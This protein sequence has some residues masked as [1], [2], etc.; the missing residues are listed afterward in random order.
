MLRCASRVAP[1]P[2]NLETNRDTKHQIFQLDTAIK[3][4]C[5]MLGWA[6]ELTSLLQAK[7]NLGGNMLYEILTQKDISTIIPDQFFFQ[8]IWNG[9]LVQLL[10]MENAQNQFAGYGIEFPRVIASMIEQLKEN[11]PKGGVAS[12]AAVKPQDQEA[13]NKEEEEDEDPA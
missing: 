4:I 7:T 5:S 6:P 13:Q 12:A 1:T 9:I 8:N 11:L 10:A 2:I 3:R